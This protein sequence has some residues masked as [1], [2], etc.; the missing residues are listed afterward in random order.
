L[1]FYKD[2]SISYR[3]L[4]SIKQKNSASEQSSRKTSKFDNLTMNELVL[5]D[6][7]Q[8]MGMK[9]RQSTC[10]SEV[11][12]TLNLSPHNFHLNNNREPNST[13]VNEFLPPSSH[14]S[15]MNSF[16]GISYPTTASDFANDLNEFRQHCSRNFSKSKIK[17]I[18][19]TFTV[20]LMYIVCSTPYFVGLLMSLTLDPTKIS[21][22]ASKS[23]HT[24]VS[25]F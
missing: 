10:Q 23:S 5:K 25:L 18:R 16:A 8:R 2:S 13:Q 21:I 1:I 19:L 6:I 3:V 9:R 12:D 4:S 15:K 7:N 11:T 20:I 24:N 17:T 14:S 22:A